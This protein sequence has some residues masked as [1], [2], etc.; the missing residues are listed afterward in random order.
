LRK[1][2]IKKYTGDIKPIEKMPGKK[3][4]K[5]TVAS[6]KP[7][8]DINRPKKA[9]TAYILF[10]ND[11]RQQVKAS[12]PEM[13]SNQLMVELGRLWKLLS[14]EEKAVYNT[15]FE[16]EKARYAQEMASYSPPA[17]QEAHKKVE[18]KKPMNAYVV[19]CKEKR[20]QLMAQNPTMKFGEIT[21]VLA[22]QWKSMTEEEKQPYV[23]NSEEQRLAY[24]RQ[25]STPSKAVSPP[26]V[27]QSEHPSTT[28]K[29]SNPAVKKQ[30][31]KK[32]MVVE[33][34]LDDE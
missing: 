22:D 27:T 6:T 11:M 1:T 25:I 31:A 3:I 10:S 17:A 30:G 23:K 28:K 13:K 7:I 18:L 34:E 14:D 2:N 15:K 5:T 8:K 20:F 16:E 29:A 19:F 21:K 33:E 32:K 26:I 4:V 24:S 9:S 12:N